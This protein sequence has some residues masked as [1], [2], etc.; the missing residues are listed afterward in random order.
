MLAQVAPDISDDKGNPHKRMTGH[1]TGL[2]FERKS[3][4]LKQTLDLPF[5]DSSVRLLSPFTGW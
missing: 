5:V 2:F 4:L 3:S 1:S